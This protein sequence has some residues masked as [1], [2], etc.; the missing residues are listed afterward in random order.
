L[1][2]FAATA[3]PAVPVLPPV[4]LPELALE[5]LEQPAASAMTANVATAPNVLYLGH[6]LYLMVVL[7]I[8]LLAHVAPATG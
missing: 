6:G 4:L 1:K 5:L 8:E 2:F 7:S 3:A